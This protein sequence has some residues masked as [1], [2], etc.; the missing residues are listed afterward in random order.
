MMKLA[1]E[2]APRRNTP[3]AEPAPAIDLAHLAR[4][5]MGEAG[6]EREVL[7][8]FE[9]QA[10]ILLERMRTAPPPAMV[11]FAHTLKG[12][13]RGIGAWRVA[14]AAAAVELSAPSSDDHAAVEA[15]GRLAA[16]VDEA[17]AVIAEIVHGQP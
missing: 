14:E 6:L 11:A 12:S 10:G 4:M 5:T 16:A 7:T 17:S 9:R 2:A 13:A 8:L 15:L 3:P 1:A